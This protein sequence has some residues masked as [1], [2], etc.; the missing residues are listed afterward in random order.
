MENR[1]GGVIFYLRFSNLSDDLFECG[2]PWSRLACPEGR[3]HRPESR[4]C[5]LLNQREKIFFQGRKDVGFQMVTMQLLWTFWFVPL[6]SWRR[7]S[8]TSPP[9]FLSDSFLFSIQPHLLNRPGFF[10]NKK[11][12]PIQS[13]CA[14][15]DVR[16]IGRVIVRQ[17]SSMLITSTHFENVTRPYFS[18]VIKIWL[19]SYGGGEKKEHMVH[20]CIL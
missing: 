10:L 3:H 8:F 7:R 5:R 1:Q 18:R 12:K 2:S 16:R 20:I 4:P 17:V 14:C 6:D 11:L 9:G 19:S 13:R 15:N